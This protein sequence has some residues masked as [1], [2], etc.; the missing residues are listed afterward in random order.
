MGASLSVFGILRLGASLSVIECAF[1]GASLSLRS[2][3]RL[4]ASV[5][6]LGAARLGASLSVLD[7]LH[8]GSSLSLRGCARLGATLSVLDFVRLG[9]SLSLRSVLR[10]GSSLSLIGAVRVGASLAVMDFLHLGSSLAL[11]SCSRL[12]SSVSLFG[13]ALFGSSLAVLDMAKLGSSLSIRSLCRIGSSLS[14]FGG[15]RIGSSLSVFG[16]ANFGDNLSIRGALRLGGNNK[17]SSGMTDTDNTYARFQDTE[18]DFTVN[19]AR[20]L[21][22]T[23]TQGV[24]HGTWVADTALIFSDRRLKTSIEPLHRTLIAHHRKHKYPS[25]GEQRSGATNMIRKGSASGRATSMPQRQE[26]SVNSL[27]RELRPV[28]FH[29]KQGVEAKYLKFGF[30]AQE[31]ESVFPNLVH[32]GQDGMKAIAMQDLIAVLTLA[33]QTVQNQMEAQNARIEH[34]ERGDPKEMNARFE[35]LEQA[36]NTRIERLER[37][38]L[39]AFPS[40]VQTTQGADVV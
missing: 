38:I 23:E 27:L 21:S 22:M 9:A 35:R 19:G 40:P 29:M 10:L 18:V 24:L 31:V 5:S 7:F 2:L 16:L 37:L 15:S 39:S 25:G 28:S 32:T 13:Y 6:V 4:G 34:L 26:E 36:Q 20:K 33:L 11:R 12:G 1:L 30:I 3:A 8:L 14:V 17:I